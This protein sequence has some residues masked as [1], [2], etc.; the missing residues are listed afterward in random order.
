[1][2]QTGPVVLLLDMTDLLNNALAEASWWLTSGTIAAN[3]APLL[4]LALVLGWFGAMVPGPRGPLYTCACGKKMRQGGKESHA[5][6]RRRHDAHT[7]DCE[8]L[9][10][11]LVTRY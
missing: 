9:T 5:A 11:H 1:M 3:T 7:H 6:F 2:Y 10:P 4:F 8:A